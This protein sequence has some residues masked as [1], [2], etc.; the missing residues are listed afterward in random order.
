VAPGRN[1]RAM[2]TWERIL[3][4]LR[5]EKRDVA[6]AVDEFTERANA[7]LDRRERELHA[8]PEEKMAIEQERMAENDA[9]LEAI[10]RRIEGRGSV[11]G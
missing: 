3:A 6:E 7:D 11:E 2:G 9:E 8:T 5:R 4:A 10:R 1:L